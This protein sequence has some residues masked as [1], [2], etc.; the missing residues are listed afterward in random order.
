MVSKQADGVEVEWRYRPDDRA[1]Q[2]TKEHLP[3]DLAKIKVREGLAV[4]VPAAPPPVD[5]EPAEEK[6][7]RK[8]LAAKA[9]EA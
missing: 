9:V 6:S 1:K 5:V 8:S 2:G 7:P 3:A 4:Y